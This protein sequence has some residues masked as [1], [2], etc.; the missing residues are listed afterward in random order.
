MPIAIKPMLKKLEDRLNRT[1]FPPDRFEPI[2]SHESTVPDSTSEPLK[3]WK[4]PKVLGYFHLLSLI[5]NG[6]MDRWFRALDLR[7]GAV[8]AIKVMRRADSWSVYRFIR[9]VSGARVARSSQLGFFV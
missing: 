2:S 4:L 7:T 9:R 3:Q 6:G 5:G 1:S 8:C